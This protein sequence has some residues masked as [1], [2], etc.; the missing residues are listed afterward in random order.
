MPD[1]FWDDTYLVEKDGKLIRKR[2]SL[3]CDFCCS[4]L[5]ESCWTYPCGQIELPLTIDPTGLPAISDDP[6]ACCHDCKPL[7]DAK[8][9]QAL[10]KRAASVQLELAGMT[11]IGMAEDVNMVVLQPLI[12]HFQ[13]FD[14]A[15]NGEP[16]IEKAPY[17]EHR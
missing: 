4:P 1:D 15:R 13:R 14:A 9:W 3:V 5:G 16:Y 11:L 6:W 2:N 12:E 7:L 10:A 17:E 8:D